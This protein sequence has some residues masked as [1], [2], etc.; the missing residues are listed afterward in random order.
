MLVDVEFPCEN[1]GW[2]DDGICKCKDDETG[3]ISDSLNPQEG[4]SKLFQCL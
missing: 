1:D 2:K 3:A 4:I